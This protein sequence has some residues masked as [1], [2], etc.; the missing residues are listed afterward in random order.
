MR[1]IAWPRLR[2][3][4]SVR[5]G[6]SALD[7]RDCIYGSVRLQ[8]D[9]RV[10]LQADLTDAG[11]RGGKKIFDAQLVAGELRHDAPAVEDERA[12]ADLGDL[13]EIG[14]HDQNRGA[15]LQ[16]DVEQTVD[17]RLRADVH[18]GG[19]ILEHVD[20]P[21]QMQPA[22]D[23]D[24]LLVAAR[25]PLDW[26]RWIVRLQADAFAC[27]ERGIRFLGGPEVRREAASR[28]N[29]IQKRSEEHTS[30]LQSP[31]YLVCRLL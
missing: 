13:F 12:V 23:D 6:S 8:P 9:G 31:M 26:N 7:F 5:V 25:Q 17:L 20:L 30:E 11:R 3:A 2:R 14:R 29:R 1:T 24:L 22:P 18:A 4:S 21:V 19:R 10:R 16:R 15:A 28:G 27:L